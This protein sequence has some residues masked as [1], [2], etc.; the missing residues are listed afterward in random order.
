MTKCTA[1]IIRVSVGVGLLVLVGLVL[2]TQLTALSSS[3]LKDRLRGQG[4]SIQDEGVQPQ[5]FPMQVLA[6]MRYRLRIDGTAVDVFEYHTTLGAIYDASRIS[7]DG[8]TFRPGFVPF[9]GQAGSLDFFVLPHWFH[10]GRVIVL[11][12]GRQGDQLPLL[13]QVLGPQLSAE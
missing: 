5:L 2:Y 9:G 13:R 10:K 7:A 1:S 4:A 12:L 8:T 3:G 11:Y 6:G